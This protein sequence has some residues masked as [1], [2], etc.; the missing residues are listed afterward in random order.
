MKTGGRILFAPRGTVDSWLHTNSA[1]YAVHQTSMLPSRRVRVWVVYLRRIEMASPPNLSP[2]RSALA[3]RETNAR[4]RHGVRGVVRGVCLFVFVDLCAMYPIPVL[5]C[6][7]ASPSM[8]LNNM[9][10]LCCQVISGPYYSIDRV[11]TGDSLFLRG[12]A[13]SRTICRYYNW[14]ELVPWHLG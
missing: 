8:W 9:R 11:Q 7:T 1:R 14:T 6:I 5:S 13:C 10:C 4:E 3:G 12:D 2:G